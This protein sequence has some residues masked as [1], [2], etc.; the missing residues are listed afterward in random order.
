MTAWQ[1]D[2]TRPAH[3]RPD[4]ERQVGGRAE[5]SPR[6]SAGRSSTPTRCRSTP[7]CSV[8]TARPSAAEAAARAASPVWRGRRGGE[9][10]RRPLA[11]R[12]RRNPRQLGD[13]PLIFVGGTGLYFRALTEGL[14]DIP[15][16]P[17]A[18]RAAVRAEAEGEPT[19][20]LHARSPP[21]IPRPPRGSGRA[22]ASACCGRSR[23]SRRPAGRWPTFTARARP[24]PCRPARGPACSS[25]PTAPTLNARIEARFDEML[26]EGALD[27]VAA[28]AARRL[29]P[30]LPAMRAH[31]VPH[32]IAHLEGRLSR[33]EAR[34][35]AVTRHPPL[36][37]T[38]IHLGPPPDAGFRL[39]RAGG[40]GGGGGGGARLRRPRHHSGF[41]FKLAP[42]NCAER[43]RT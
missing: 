39:G 33:D 15:R 17:E 34:A 37:Q 21:A 35:L 32:L 27:E 20:T 10:L 3:R 31:G 29:D 26:R 11:E 28:L 5:G 23:S 18:V 24:P 4:G 30:A 12:G 41:I 42:R 1:S 36:R 8:L 38:P 6:S 22:T 43:M 7:T 2:E 25:L 13:A 16:V 14:S 9:F 40:G 19:P